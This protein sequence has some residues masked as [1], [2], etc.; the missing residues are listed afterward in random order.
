MEN[1]CCPFCGGTGTLRAN[2]SRKAGRWF[3]RMSCEI[4]SAQSKSFEDDKDPSEASWNDW[5]CELATRAWNM[6]LG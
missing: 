1:K 4:C 5:A 2:Y 3:V 6:R